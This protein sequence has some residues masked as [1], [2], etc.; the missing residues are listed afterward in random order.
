MEFN[1]IFKVVH[2]LM[3]EKMQVFGIGTQNP[4]SVDFLIITPNETPQKPTIWQSKTHEIR[5]S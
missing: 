1:C 3:G 4:R 2:L 5:F